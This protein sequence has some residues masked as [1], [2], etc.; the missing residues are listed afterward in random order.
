[1]SNNEAE[2]CGALAVLSHACHMRYP[3]VIIYGDSMLVVRQLTGAWRCK[4]ANLVPNYERGLAMMRQL[5][6]TCDANSFKLAHVY[7]EFNADADSLANVALDRQ[8]SVGALVVNQGW[9]NHDR[10]SA[11]S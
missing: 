3:R 1:M 5:A 2:Y 6:E 10:P 11:H 4:A 9:L 8:T 7:R